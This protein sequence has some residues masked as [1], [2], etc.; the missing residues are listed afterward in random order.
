[1]LAG[2]GGQRAHRASPPRTRLPIA[3]L[4]RALERLS[5][6]YELDRLYWDHARCARGLEATRERCSA[7]GSLRLRARRLT[8]SRFPI[9][10]SARPRLPSP[11]CAYFS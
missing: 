6:L 4:Q 2:G 9:S 11:P 8:L 5:S 10:P 3:P 1:M 7:R